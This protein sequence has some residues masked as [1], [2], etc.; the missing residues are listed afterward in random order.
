MC[1][2]KDGNHHQ[3]AEL[4]SAYLDNMVTADERRLVESHLASCQACEQQLLALRQVV[5]LVRQ[6]PSVVPP[7]AFVLREADVAPRSSFTRL[8]RLLPAWSGW[9]TALATGAALLLCLT[10]LGLTL[11]RT[12]TQPSNLAMQLTTPGVPSNASQPL[13]TQTSEPVQGQ[14]ITEAMGAPLPTTLLAS[15]VPTQLTSGPIPEGLPAKAQRTVTPALDLA[16]K[17]APAVPTG[18]LPGMPTVA[19]SSLCEEDRGCQLTGAPASPSATFVLPVAPAPEV[20]ATATPVAT[21]LAGVTVPQ[22][23]MAPAVAVTTTPVS[24][25]TPPA[26]QAPQG[27]SRDA[28]R[29]AGAAPSGVLPM[30]SG[31]RKPVLITV[32]SPT[33]VVGSGMITI[34]GRLPLPEG[35]LLQA[36]IWRDGRPLEWAVP[37][38]QLTRLSAAGRFLLRLRARL[39]QADLDLSKASP[40][41]FEIRIRS[42]DERLSVETRLP[43]SETSHDNT[44]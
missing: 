37:E 29:A 32:V 13:P 31:T 5:G 35:V 27:E 33:L 36:E 10:F 2:S 21:D 42:L 22:V 4:L 19:V 12:G 25:G 15:G 23:A 8:R 11:L 28:L 14:T 6:L 34:S 17:R 43:L 24:P 9:A 40:G 30:A 1:E 3:V 16:E 18:E 7:R 38:S 41:E 26:E 44:P 39:D 20:R